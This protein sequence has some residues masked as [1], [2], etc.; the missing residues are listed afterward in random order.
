[1]PE[2]SRKRMFGFSWEGRPPFRPT[3]QRERLDVRVLP[4]WTAI[5]SSLSSDGIFTLPVED[6]DD[7]QDKAA[8]S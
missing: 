1:M 7:F 6:E 3:N 2:A 5:K 8:P 4:L